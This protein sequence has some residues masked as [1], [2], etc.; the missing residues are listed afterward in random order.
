MYNGYCERV[1]LEDV[2][3]LCKAFEC[4]VCDILVYEPPKTK[5]KK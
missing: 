3:K 2:G 4:D 5:S 1:S